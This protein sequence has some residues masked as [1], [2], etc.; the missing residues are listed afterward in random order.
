MPFSLQLE[1]DSGIVI[2][3]CTGVFELSDAKEGAQA[4]WGNPQWSG[5][6]IV[7]DFRSARLN[8][9]PAEVRELAEFFLGHQP[10]NPPPKVA[11]LTSRDSDFGLARMFEVFREHPAT[12][13]QIFRDHEE[14]LSWARGE[15]KTTPGAPPSPG[16]GS[17]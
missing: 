3:T 12:E 7:W 6:P 16:R 1:P 15:V 14:A 10:R 4:V 17:V 2:A 8:F 11:I 9:R 5:R 13:V